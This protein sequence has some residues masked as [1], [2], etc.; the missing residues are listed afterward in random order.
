MY[1]FSRYFAAFLLLAYGFA[2]ING[3]QF[4]V[5]DS[6]LDKPLRDVS[7]FW[8]TWYYFGYSA[9]YSTILALVQIGGAIALMIRR[10]A[11][12]GACVLL[13]VVSNI[14]LIDIFYGVD[15]SALGAAIAIEACLVRVLFEHRRRMALLL[16]PQAE[17][18]KRRRVLAAAVAT[19][20]V[21]ATFS[22]TYYTAH[23]NNIEPTPID[24]T[25]AV[26]SVAGAENRVP[27]HV[28]FERT[29]AW[30]CVFRY[31]TGSQDHHFEL[32]P[33]GSRVRIWTHWKVK[34]PLLMEGP[35]DASRGTVT[36]TGRLP[37]STQPVTLRLSRLRP[38]R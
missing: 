11:L 38:P 8:L 29:R 24:G 26:T 2:K 7:G 37:H 12:I 34:G 35:Y 21:A 18:P 23:Y 15:C 10:L 13:P 22:L 32:D 1:A 33:N 3:S 20:F 19:L 17:T 5:L 6:E 28:Y 31:P 16:L 9:V 25:W 4:T 30:W 14:I 27:T 36:L